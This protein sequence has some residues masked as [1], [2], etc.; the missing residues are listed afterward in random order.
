MPLADSTSTG[1]TILFALVGGGAAGTLA[2]TFWRIRHERAEAWRSRLLD[3]ADDFATGVLQALMKLERMSGWIAFSDDSDYGYL[4]TAQAEGMKEADALIAEAR[5][6]L[7]RIHLL[8]GSASVAGS[9]AT[10]L[11]EKLREASKALWHDPEMGG[12][13]VAAADKAL[14]A[15]REALEGF[16]TAGRLAAWKGRV[17]H[18]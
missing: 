3:A 1:L 6:R 8:F 2:S 11:V 13:D 7:A 5:A 14:L 18:A 12:V 16:G 9:W 4:T 10:E 15:A 17:E